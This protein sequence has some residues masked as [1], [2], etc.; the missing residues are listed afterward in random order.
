MDFYAG[1]AAGTSA[2]YPAKWR[3]SH[4]V[5]VVALA[6]HAG[7]DAERRLKLALRDTLGLRPA[8]IGRDADGR[9]VLGRAIVVPDLPYGLEVVAGELRGDPDAARVVSVEVEGE[10]VRLRSPEDTIMAYAESGWDTYHARDWERALA[11]YA[12]MRDEIDH[13]RLRA[14][15][16]ERRMPG[17]VEEVISGRPLPDAPRPLF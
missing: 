4:D 12:A 1:G 15:A 17:V 3:A 8:V 16:R 14:R 6:V 9:D 5:D 7:I 13:E 2:A 11:V 10:T